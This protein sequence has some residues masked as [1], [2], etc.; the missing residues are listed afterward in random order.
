MEKMTGKKIAIMGQGINRLF[1]V[2]FPLIEPDTIISFENTK[3]S[4]EPMLINLFIE[5]GLLLYDNSTQQ[6][7]TTKKVAELIKESLDE[8]GWEDYRW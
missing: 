3:N 4:L 1:S 5:Q 8:I 6:V 2:M 7:V